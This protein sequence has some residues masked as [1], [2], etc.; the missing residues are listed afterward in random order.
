MRNN[1]R[2]QWS[3]YGKHPSAR[4][5]FRLGDVYPL[6]KALAQW[7]ERG[8]ERIVAAHE[9]VPRYCSWRFWI[10][11][12]KK[13]HVAC[14]LLKTSMD[15]IGRPHPLLMIGFGFLADWYE[16]WDLAPFVFEKAWVEMEYISAKSIIDLKMFESEIQK[17]RTPV[18]EWSALRQSRGNADWR[19]LPVETFR[20]KLCSLAG[21]EFFLRLD[22]QHFD[23]F[24]LTG[25][26]HRL[27]KANCESPP[28]A[29]FIGGTNRETYLSVFRRP[30]TITDFIR[31]WSISV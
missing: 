23:S 16:N 11:E 29:V 13:N 28:S 10:Q 8:H 3:A 1:G 18:V 30:L 31:L 25:L 9:L 4:D 19:D 27:L 21:L 7:M 5:Y 14:G 6:N 20:E 17:M 24:D 22:S 2:W 15:T 12:A 26:C